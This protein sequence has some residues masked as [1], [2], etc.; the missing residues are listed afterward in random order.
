MV[1][2]G[3]ILFNLGFVN[4]FICFCNFDGFN[5]LYINVRSLKVFVVSSDNGGIKVCKI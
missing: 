5:I 3:D 2:S 1:F 4:N